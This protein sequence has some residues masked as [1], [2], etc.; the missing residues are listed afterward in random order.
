VVVLSHSHSWYSIYFLLSKYLVLVI[1]I[2]FS[3]SN[4]PAPTVLYFSLYQLTGSEIHTPFSISLFLF[5]LA[6]SLLAFNSSICQ[7]NYFST[8]KKLVRQRRHRWFRLFCLAEPSACRVSSD[9]EQTVMR[10]S[11]HTLPYPSPLRAPTPACS[12]RPL[13][14]SS[15]AAANCQPAHLAFLETP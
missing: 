6:P 9:E 11:L 13:A 5:S 14:R 15:S 2:L 8:P 12:R 7:Y 10:D 3:K 4:F 1:D